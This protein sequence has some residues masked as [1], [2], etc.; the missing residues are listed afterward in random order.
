[1]HFDL[2]DQA[3][4]RGQTHLHRAVARGYF[5]ERWRSAAGQERFLGHVRALVRSADAVT[6]IKTINWE[7]AKKK[8]H[9]LK[10][11]DPIPSR[12]GVADAAADW[13]EVA[14]ATR[15]NEKGQALA[16]TWVK[17]Y[18]LRSFTGMLGAIDGDSIR[19]YRLWLEKQKVGE[20]TLSA[21]TVARVLSCNLPHYSEALFH[22]PQR[23]GSSIVSQRCVRSGDFVARSAA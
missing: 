14:V 22:F 3:V 21:N 2:L 1:V 18:L 8:F 19:R 4:S 6:R 12:V 16:A 17:L 11:G 5:S 7:K 20:G 9:K 13:L 23:H 15:R 10:A